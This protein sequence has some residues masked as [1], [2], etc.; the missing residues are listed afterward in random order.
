VTVT[1]DDDI[2][3]SP[4]ERRT[5][6]ITHQLTSTDVA[7]NGRRRD[8]SV[9]IRDNDTVGITLSQNTLTVK[10]EAAYTVVLTSQPTGEVTI[11][12]TSEDGTVATVSGVLRFTAAN[13]NQPQSVTVTGINATS[14]P[15]QTTRIT[16]SAAGGDYNG[17]S[18]GSVAITTTNE[19]TSEVILSR[20]EL[21]VDEAGGTATYTVRLAS[22]PTGEVTVTPSSS[23]ETVATVSEALTFTTSNWQTVQEVTVTAVEDRIDNDP[24]RTAR[25]THGVTGGGYAGAEVAEVLVTATDDDTVGVT[26]SATEVG[27]A[28]AN[29]SDQGSTYSNTTTYTVVLDT[30]PTG[31]VTVTPSS[32]DGTVATVSR[33]LRFTTSNWQIPQ[34][35][36][37]TGVDDNIDNDPEWLLWLAANRPQQLNRRVTISHS[38]SGGDYGEVEIAGVAVTVTDDG[39]TAGVQVTTVKELSNLNSFDFSEADE[40]LDYKVV[41]TSQPTADVTVKPR[42]RHHN[43]AAYWG[44]TLSLTSM[45]FTSANW[46]QPQTVTESGPGS[47]HNC[48]G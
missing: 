46:N 21:S 15:G 5:A 28:E 20:S 17:V 37:V 22:P 39:D 38:V 24:D 32:S 9:T 31:D 34:E 29:W 45:T 26:V 44:A 14:N 3:N 43:Y 18:M 30:Q 7:Y 33:A 40:T 42:F 19:E 12:P 8:V 4:T 2:D 6:R 36:T 35:V 25:I 41:L 27:V 13:W 10:E 47:D 1:V 16:H 11:T 48:G 23:D